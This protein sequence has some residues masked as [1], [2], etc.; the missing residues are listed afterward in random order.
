MTNA[1]T[2]RRLDESGYV[3]MPGLMELDLLSRLRQRVEELLASEGDAAGSEFR[4]EPGARRLANLVNKGSVFREIIVH[5]V[6]LPLVRHVLENA[7]LSSLNARSV[8]PGWDKP[9]PLHCD[10]G[11][12]PDE[13]GPW[14][15]N[16]VWM[17]DDF[18][19]HNGALRVVPGSHRGHR[20]PQ[21]ALADP[22]ADHPQQTVITAP[23]G[24]VIVMN[25]HL[26]HGGMPNRTFRPRTAVHAFYC[27]RDKPQQQYQK[28]L[29]DAELQRTL[30]PELREL[31][32]LDDPLND[33]L[34]NETFTR[35]GFLV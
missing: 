26:W 4:T 17:L 5:P 31:L 29:L 3:L 19:E 7:K 27:R 14:V 12:L 22:L 28:S 9:Q 18:T 25:A 30:P 34:S 20:L 10:M 23:A 32:A 21:D 6:V 8:N 15:C 35:S 24:S 16:T 2:C 13:Q 1:Q 33:D 11:A